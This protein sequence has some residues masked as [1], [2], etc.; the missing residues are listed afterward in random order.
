MIEQAFFSHDPIDRHLGS[1]VLLFLRQDRHNL[2]RCQI[3]KARIIDGV[4][5]CL[6][7]LSAEFVGHSPHRSLTAIEAEPLPIDVQLP[8]P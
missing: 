2:T 6:A 3:R 8:A 4:N 7:L 5:H 1:N